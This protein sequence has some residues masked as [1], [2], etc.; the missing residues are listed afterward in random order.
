MAIRSPTQHYDEVR[1]DKIRDGSLVQ[2]IARVIESHPE[3]SVV[4]LKVSDGHGTVTLVLQDYSEPIPKD[5]IV[6]V[7]AQY[8][9]NEFI[10]DYLRPLA[11]FDLETYSAYALRHT[12]VGEEQ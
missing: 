7:F 8:K 10:V 5:T 4:A 3:G 6:Q 11:N 2:F 9:A 12:E 1:L